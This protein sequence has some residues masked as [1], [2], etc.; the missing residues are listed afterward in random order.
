MDS[1]AL[2]ACS[3]LGST[4]ARPFDAHQYASYQHEQRRSD[5]HNRVD[6][7]W[8]FRMIAHTETLDVDVLQGT[9][10]CKALGPTPKRQRWG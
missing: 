8:L 4:E 10:Y 9:M 5:E 7:V 3:Q 6:A 2:A 1:P